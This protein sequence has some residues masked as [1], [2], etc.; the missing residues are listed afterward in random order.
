[1]QPS[2]LYKHKYDCTLD[3]RATRLSPDQVSPIHKLICS[4]YFFR[5][6]RRVT[7]SNSLYGEKTLLKLSPSPL[8]LSLF[9]SEER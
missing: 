7:I 1:M 5:P 8:S 2:L 3:K 6:W 9:S 4:N